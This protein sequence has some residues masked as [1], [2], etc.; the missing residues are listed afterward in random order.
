[1][2]WYL[3]IL[4]VAGVV[5]F[6][7]FWLDKHRAARGGRR[8]P[9]RTLHALELCGGWAGA[10]TAMALVRHKNRKPRYWL[11]TAMIAATHLAAVWW[12]V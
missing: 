6:A 2:R 1:M 7:A 12:M 4:L 9:E 11:V 3:A 10:I 5:T 8:I